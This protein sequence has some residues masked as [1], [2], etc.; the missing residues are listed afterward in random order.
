M[1]KLLAYPHE[2]LPADRVGL[3]STAARRLKLLAG[4][5]LVATVERPEAPRLIVAGWAETANVGPDGCLLAPDLLGRLGIEPG[6]TVCLDSARLPQPWF[7]SFFWDY[8]EPESAARAEDLLI[9]LDT[10]SSMEGK[11]LHSAKRALYA[12]LERKRE[13]TGARPPQEAEPL[14]RIGLLTFGGEGRAGVRIACAPAGGNEGPLLSAIERCR[15]GGMTPMAEALTEALAVLETLEP[16]PDSRRRL[17]LVT[18]GHPCPGAAADVEALLP[19]LAA[20]R[21]RVATVGVGDGFDRNLLSRLAAGTN[22]PFVEVQRIRE[23]LQTL[24]SLA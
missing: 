4:E 14:D 10:S 21:V 3:P 6:Q 5:P 19:A 16:S 8:E 2:D 24:E 18:D 7:W 9:L 12:L 11:P 22:A 23:L 17:I 15:A 20:A 1:L 13:R